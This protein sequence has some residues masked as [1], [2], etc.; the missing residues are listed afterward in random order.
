TGF[1]GL[2][3]L[4]YT[5]QVGREAMES[6]VIFIV[7]SVAELVEKLADFTGNRAKPTGCYQ[8]DVQKTGEG[9]RFF[10]NDEDSREVINKWLAKG[11]FKK[12]AELWTKGGFIDWKLLY[13]GGRPLRTG[14]PTYP[15]ALEY[16]GIA[17]QPP[18]TAPPPPG[19][20][21]WLHPLLHENTSD[22]SQQCFSSTFTGKEF[23]LKDH[24][25]KGQKVLPGVAYLEMAR[26]AVKRASREFSNG[27]RG[28]RLKNI[29]WARPIVV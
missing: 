23:F 16:F 20:N 19:S 21:G 15:F 18:K 27:N 17:E 14:L 5:L 9:I 1:P 2:R 3:D 4:A 28:I 11:K 10:E 13:R 6:R 7:Q 24:Q 8:G 22:L 25:V 12:L 29:V 26:E